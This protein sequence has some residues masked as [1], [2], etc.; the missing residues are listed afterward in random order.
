MMTHAGHQ[1]KWQDTAQASLTWIWH[2]WHKYRRRLRLYV[3]LIS[4]PPD[5]EANQRAQL[6]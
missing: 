1:S 4:V 2:V 3:I 6:S 5:G